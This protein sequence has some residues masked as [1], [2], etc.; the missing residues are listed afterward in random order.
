MDLNLQVHGRDSLSPFY[1]PFLYD[2]SYIDDPQKV[3]RSK[4][5]QPSVRNNPN[6]T[7]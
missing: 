3:P 6:I 1:L 2:L 7:S 4:M 5:H